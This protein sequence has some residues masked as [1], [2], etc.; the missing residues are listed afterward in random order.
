MP[1]TETRLIW[2][3]TA[4]EL[5]DVGDIYTAECGPYGF[6]VSR[7]PDRGYRLQGWKVRP[8]DWPLLV[9]ENDDFGLEE[10]KARAERLAD[11]R[12][13]VIIEG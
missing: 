8:Q 1:T 3:Q 2:I 9:W 10:A 13:P 5:G 6:E 12:V 7:T 4:R 11:E